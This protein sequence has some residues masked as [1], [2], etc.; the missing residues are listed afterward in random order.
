MNIYVGNLAREVEEDDV[1]GVFE[2]F[3]EV[4]SVNIL[5][6]RSTGESKGF[7]FVK[8]PAESEARKAIEDADGSELKGL[9][10]KVNEAHPRPAPGPRGG[11][12]FR[13]GRG[14]GGG[15]RGGGRAGGRSGG[16]GRRRY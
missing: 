1:R 16:G 7:G 8:M 12:G 6:D 14:R 11:G 3:G 13:G 9:N 2:A 10:I 5:R 4:D 15:G